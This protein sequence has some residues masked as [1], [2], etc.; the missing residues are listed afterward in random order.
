MIMLDRKFSA[1]NSPQHWGDK[2]LISGYTW[3]NEPAVR[4]IGSGGQ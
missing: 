2:L 3:Q 4:F 1:L